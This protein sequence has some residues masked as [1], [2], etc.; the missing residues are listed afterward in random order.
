M[1]EAAVLH[2]YDDDVFDLRRSCSQD[3]RAQ[4]GTRGYTTGCFEEGSAIHSLVIRQECEFCVEKTLPNVRTSTVKIS[5]PRRDR[6]RL[7]LRQRLPGS[8]GLWQ[9]G[10]AVTPELA[11]AI[12]PHIQWFGSY[13]KSSELKKI[14]VWLTV[15]QGRIEFLTPASSYKVKRVRRN[16]QVICIPGRGNGPEIRGKAEIVTDRDAAQRVYR[17]YQKTH[18]FMMLFLARGIRQRIESGEQ[19]VIRVQPDDPN[20]LSGVTDPPF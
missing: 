9:T 2:H 4:R 16:A 13:N 14:K 6:G 10:E 11:Q 18:P 19:V 5:P 7:L 17:A 12:K 8:D 3:L 20:P 15:N 1:V